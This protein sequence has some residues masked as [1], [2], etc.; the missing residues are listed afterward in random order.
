MVVAKTVLRFS[1]S[2]EH[3]RASRMHDLAAT[4]TQ[5]EY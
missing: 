5:A 1:R 4:P 2:V 3:R